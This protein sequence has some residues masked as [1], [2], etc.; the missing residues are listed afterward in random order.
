MPYQVTIF[1]IFLGF[2][3]FEIARQ[4][5][6]QKEKSKASDVKVELIGGILLVTFTQPFVLF[7]GAGLASALL[8]QYQDALISLPFVAGFA[9]LI[10]FDDLVQ[11][12]WHR[13]SHT[14]PWL[15]N[16]HRSHHN[17]EY[18][19]IRIVYRNNAF[20][21]LFMP[22][23]W[24][25]GV[26]LYLGLA[27]VYIYYTI[28]KMTII[29]GAHS[30]Q[31]WDQPLYRIKALHPLMWVVE[32]VIST[33]TTHSAHH[34]KHLADGV[35]NYKGNFGNMLFFWDVLFGTAKITRQVP[36][37]FGVENLPDLEA[38]EQLFWPLVRSE[39]TAAV[40]AAPEPAE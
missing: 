33:P 38:S 25:T 30:N 8:P 16:L 4:T 40:T 34:G 15:Y 22:N 2:G 9:L 27:E 13:A 26:L 7:C 32:R 24:T 6:L 35:T 12:W 17:A 18:M 5:F 29:F 10:L 23:L 39:A 14:F 11:Y 20:Y 36:P 21:Y 3:L 19:S 31:R 1:L 28:I 37:E